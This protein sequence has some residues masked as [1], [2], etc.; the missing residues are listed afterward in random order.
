MRGDNNDIR[1][2]FLKNLLLLYSLLIP[3]LLFAQ[4]T[5]FDDLFQELS[6]YLQLD[7][8]GSTLTPESLK[9]VPSAVSVFTHSEIQRLGL[10][11]LDELM[12]LVP[13]FQSY[14][15]TGTSLNYSYSSRGRRI[16]GGGS[17][18]LILVDGQRLQESRISG[19]SS[20]VPKFPLMHINQVE[21]IRGPGS[22]IYGSNAMMGI[23]NITTRSDVNEFSASYGSFNRKKLYLLKSLNSGELFLDIF[24]HLE[25][26]DGDDYRLQ[27]SFSSN[28]VASDDPREFA[29]LSIKANWQD[30][31]II[32]QHYQFRADNYYILSRL[33]SN[34]INQSNAKLS[35][36][37]LQ[38]EFNWLQFTS[39]FWVSYN[40]SEL[41]FPTQLSPPGF[42]SGSK[43]TPSSSA[44]VY[45]RPVFDN[46]RE[47]RA[48]WHNNWQVS[49]QS[50]VQFGIESR[51]IFAPEAVAFS[52]FDLAALTT[53]NLPVNS[54]NSNDITTVVQSRS[55][56]K[57]IG[58]YSQYQDL[59]N[60]TSHITLGLRYDNFS[61]I[62]SK[63]SP[64]L[65][66]VQE[67]N[68]QQNLKLLYG[69][70]FRAPVESELNLQ[71][72]PEVLGNPNLDPE[73]VKTWELIWLGHW[74]NTGF[75][76]G[77]FENYFD[78][79]IIRA[80]N[81]G[82][83]HQYQNIDQDPS[84]GFEFE[85]SH[86]PNPHWLLRTTYTHFTKT[87]HLTFFE[88]DRF[89]SILVNY[90]KDNWN[91]N[92]VA[93]WFNE[94]NS[95]AIGNL[96]TLTSVDEYWLLSAKIAYKTS[97]NWKFYGQAKNLLDKDYLTPP[98]MPNR[99]RQILAGIVWEF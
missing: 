28:L 88:A 64:R 37:S 2:V 27:D 79:A 90:Q 33:L 8:T 43:S 99:G 53:G 16:A 46:Y 70:A 81:T 85:I 18:I 25:S 92:L 69:E 87:P 61:S 35:S 80:L 42:L 72:N 58:L 98:A 73:S 77:Y 95:A 21:F 57:V 89:S 19:G 49:P 1:G 32:F 75:S 96:N 71:N 83:E 6:E 97:T 9:T 51:Q 36:I 44:P 76:L 34:G 29:T 78:N 93:T 86:M 63:F 91:S 68:P 45:V 13:G 3:S 82:G 54:S 52:N 15:S 50:S 84:K 10:D 94:R 7:I 26:D 62:G 40:R 17:E 74:S 41:E 30:T 4:P 47:F 55:N 48:Q 23:I 65:S 22:T 56:R 24:V 14:R 39:Y 5:E 60:Q 12:N 11:T 20:I 31:N 67:L 66:L 59:I 38:Q